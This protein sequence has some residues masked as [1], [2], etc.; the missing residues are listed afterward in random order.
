MRRAIRI[1]VLGLLACSLLAA[2]ASA[3]RP[4]QTFIPVDDLFVDPF[5]SGACGV[6][7]TVSATGHV[8]LRAFTDANGNLV[9]E[10]NNYAID[11][12]FSSE[13][14]AIHAKDV[15]VDRVTYFEDGGLIDIIIGSVQSFSIPGQ[16]RVYADVGRS[17]LEIDANGNTTLTP[18]SGQHDPDQTAVICDILG[19]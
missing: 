7:V 5:L 3:G 11:L 13:N 17:M 4:A 18:L 15:G 1:T 6:D 8:I 12:T 10:V 16:G 2:P 14:A 9:R 19:D